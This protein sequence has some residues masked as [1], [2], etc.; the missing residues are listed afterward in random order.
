VGLKETYTRAFIGLAPS[1]AHWGLTHPVT[2]IGKMFVS[3]ILRWYRTLVP[4][5]LRRYDEIH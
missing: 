1:L 5:T 3:A 4:G 2:I